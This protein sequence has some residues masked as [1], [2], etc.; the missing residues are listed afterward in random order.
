LFGT[1][2]HNLRK[3]ILVFILIPRGGEV[4]SKT[5]VC[6]MLRG[7]KGGAFMRAVRVQCEPVGI[8]FVCLSAEL[9]VCV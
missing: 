5:P 2:I 4:V 1:K 9:S 6:L 7:G 8:M 3:N